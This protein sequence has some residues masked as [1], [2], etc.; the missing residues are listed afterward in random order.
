[1][2]TVHHLPGCRFVADDEVRQLPRRVKDGDATLGWE[3]DDRLRVFVNE[4]TA[5]FEA[6][7]PLE[8]RSDFYL[9]ARSSTPEGLVRQLARNDNRRHDRLSEIVKANERAAASAKRDYDD[10]F[11]DAADKLQF[12]LRRDLGQHYGGLTRRLYPISGR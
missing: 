5:E 3:G 2:D 11:D 8:D 6:W 1:M 10:A 9:A 12:A 7:A 4:R